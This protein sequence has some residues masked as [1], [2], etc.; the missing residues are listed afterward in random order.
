MVHQHTTRTTARWYFSPNVANFTA[1]GL[2]KRKISQEED[3][4]GQ[5]KK[6]W[7]QERKGDKKA[8]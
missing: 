5:G 3:T 6:K 1:N 4:A 7:G 2:R 8:G